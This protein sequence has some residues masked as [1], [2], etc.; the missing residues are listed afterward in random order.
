M[1]G[2]V[3]PSS[4]NNTS[5]DPNK[6][7][8]VPLTIITTLFFMWGFITCMNDILIPKFKVVFDLSG[9]EALLVQSA[10][11]G[12]F[13]F[14]SLI[15]FLLSISGVDL[16]AKY[17]Y[18]KAIIVG[19]LVCALG[20][21]GFIPAAE[22]ASYNLFLAS[23]FV[24]ASGVTILQMGANPYVTLLG[25]PGG[26]SSRLN[27]TQ[28]FNSLGTTV[29]PVVGGILIFSCL[30]EAN[31]LDSVVMPY[32]ALAL[33]LMALALFIL[34]SDLPAVTDNSTET[35]QKGKGAFAYS[36]LIL[37]VVCIF[38]YVG[39]EVSIGSTI[40]NYLELD[41]I[42]GLGHDEADKYLAV[43]WGG[44][45]IGRFFASI[46][47]NEETII[48]EKIGAIIGILGFG[49]ILALFLTNKEIMLS[50]IITPCE[51][52]KSLA[53]D[54]NSALIF[55]GVVISNIVAF[56]IG[57]RKP[58]A[59]LGIFSLIVCGLLLFVIV[60]NGLP[61]MWAI[62]VI[63]LFNSIMFPT[64]F[65]LAIKGLGIDTSQGSSL[66]VMAIVGGAFI[67]ILQGLIWD[68]TGSLQL[69]FI[70]PLACYVYIAFYGFVGS[71]PKQVN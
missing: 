42:A 35:L 57:K 38:A 2:G 67:P 30:P 53:W 33:T 26:A 21:F 39:G 34:F 44:A 45:M 15:Y 50:F 5:F 4:N 28:A 48:K 14:I 3:A 65:S 61:A 43:Y 36:H 12:A 62:L 18:K 41:N 19:L 13:F 22:M 6:N 27:M 63:G 29:A 59:T 69:S 1:A 23:L 16:I 54:F 68:S 71:K 55:I 8:S 11:F 70:V 25:S 46:F 40:I 56:I 20:C 51:G 32:V 58:G 31:P 7:Y 64:I 49:V 37:G 47:L 17:G 66:L 52:A 24:L 9:T 60:G 10:F